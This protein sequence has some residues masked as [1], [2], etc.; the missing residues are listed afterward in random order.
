MPSNINDIDE[1]VLLEFESSEKE[2][3]RRRDSSI[4]KDLLNNDGEA[5]IG[6]QSRVDE[7]QTQEERSPEVKRSQND[8]L[9]LV[10]PVE[11]YPGPPNRTVFNRSLE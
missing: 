3:K 11:D 2:R 10:E 6:S 1:A 4:G 8:P 7:Q 5:L 9:I